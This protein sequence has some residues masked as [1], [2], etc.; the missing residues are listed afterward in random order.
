MAEFVGQP[1]INIIEASLEK[2]MLFPF[3]IGWTRNKQVTG[4]GLGSGYDA[5]RVVLGLRPESIEL[6]GD[7]PFPAKVISCEYMGDSYVARLE[8]KDSILCVSNVRAPL[9]DGDTVKFSFE[10]KNLL[11]FDS[12]TGVRLNI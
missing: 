9:T 8:F 7:A 6:A 2:G 4:E 11:F 1:K 3:G 12:G 5:G 10:L